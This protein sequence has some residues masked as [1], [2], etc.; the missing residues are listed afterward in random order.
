[1]GKLHQKLVQLLDLQGPLFIFEMNRVALEHDT[2]PFFKPIA[3]FPSVR[4]DIA[5]VVDASIAVEDLKQCIIKTAGILLKKVLVFDV[6]HKIDPSKNQLS[7]NQDNSTKGLSQKSVAF[8]LLFQAQDATLEDNQIKNIMDQ[9][10][11]AL[12]QTF[13]AVLR[14]AHH[15]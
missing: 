9:I 7:M 15:E 1:M 2:A 13:Q 10:S 14:D 5:L 8:G 6:Y 12:Q 3:K 4:R 11:V